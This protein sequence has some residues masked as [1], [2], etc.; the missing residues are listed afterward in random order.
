MAA[1]H[2][3]FVMGQM[4]KWIFLFFVWIYT[5]RRGVEFFQLDNIVDGKAVAMGGFLS[6]WL[7]ACEPCNQHFLC[8][9]M[10]GL[11]LRLG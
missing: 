6:L 7:G 5:N 11:L 9:S 3:T 1:K 10:S 4:A 8:V 2:F